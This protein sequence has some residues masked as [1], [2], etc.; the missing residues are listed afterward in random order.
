M[1]LKRVLVTGA[2][3]FIGSNLTRKLLE[4]GFDVGIIRRKQT[5][6][7]RIKDIGD[8]LYLL[9]ADIGD[10]E[11][12]QGAL[13]EF[14]PEAVVH[15]AAYYAVSHERSDI[16]RMMSCNVAGAVNLLECSVDCGVRMFVNTS[17]CFVYAGKKGAIREDESPDPFNLYALTKLQAEDACTF[18][19]GRYGMQAVTLR[20]FPPYG[21]YD[22]MRRLIPS[23]IMAFMKGG[24]P[25]M[26]TG[27]Q[28][29]DFTYVD[30]ISEAYVKA[31]RRA[32]FQ[33]PHE[34]FNIGTGKAVSVRSVAE[35]IA[36]LTGS[37]V[38]PEWGAIPHRENEIWH[39][40][41]DTSK[42]RSALGWKARRMADEGLKLTV[43]WY[44][45]KN[46]RTIS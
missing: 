17:T 40:R 25:K 20:L 34:V 36:E 26:T 11:S 2:S 30:D 33:N 43:E 38:K 12:V 46:N 35:K 3:G 10:A 7:S 4:E 9:T 5:D 18:Y 6:M 42:A 45:D 8:K 14:R 41:A 23:T 37:G 13:S 27:K 19:A 21:P 39:L 16:P 15:L 1:G 32:K 22:H 31:L 44:K 29:W 28:E 24:R